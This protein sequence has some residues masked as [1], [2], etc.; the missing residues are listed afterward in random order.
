[1]F[2]SVVGVG[3]LAGWRV[4]VVVGAPGLL[5]GGGAGLLR[6]GLSGRVI[7]KRT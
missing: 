7:K 2:L 3:G 5:L 6:T 1:M 4:V